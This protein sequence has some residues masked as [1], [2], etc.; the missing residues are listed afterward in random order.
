MTIGIK[1]SRRYVLNVV[2]AHL[3][4]DGTEQA[5]LREHAVHGPVSAVL[6]EDKANGSAVI[7][8]LKEKISGLVAV[9][10]AGGKQGRMAA[11]VPEWQANNWYLDRTAAWTDAFITQITLFPRAKHDDIA[12]TM[13]QAAVWLQANTYELGLIDYFKGIAAG[14]FKLPT[15][16]SKLAVVASA[17]TTRI[18][19]M[20][21]AP[22]CCSSPLP[23]V[24]AGGQVRCN[25]CGLQR[26]PEGE[27]P[28]FSF[29]VSRN[30]VLSGRIHAQIRK[31]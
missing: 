9:N 4:L 2:N 18:P 20:E 3:D 11:A 15:E 19:K 13:S 26:W 29:G 23:I 25:N 17:S 7:A 30:D 27:K 22:S 1:G 24:I 28:T 12:D 31:S 14:T 5:I 16:R 6:C 10:P 8:H 21:Q